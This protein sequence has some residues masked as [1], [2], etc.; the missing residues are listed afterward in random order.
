MQITVDDD[1]YDFVIEY[2]ILGSLCISFERYGLQ[3]VLA[4]LIPSLSE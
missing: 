3:Q 2:P 1:K 4:E